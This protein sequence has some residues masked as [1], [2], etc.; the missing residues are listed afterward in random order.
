MIHELKT[1]PEYWAE[2]FFGHKTFEVRQN[3]RDY[4]IGDKLILCEWD[5]DKKEYTGRQLA[6]TIT[7]ILEGGQFGIEKGAVVM[8]IQ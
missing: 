6:R 8:S 7:Y 3:D 4:K 2:I 1:W 5:N